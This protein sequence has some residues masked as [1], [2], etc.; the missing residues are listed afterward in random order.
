MARRSN[1]I[2]VN[3][4]TPCAVPPPED[5]RL[6]DV[7]HTV[8]MAIETVDVKLGKKIFKD[9]GLRLVLGDAQAIKPGSRET[10]DHVLNS[11]STRARQTMSLPQAPR[12]LIHTK[13]HV[14][15]TNA[16]ANPYRGRCWTYVFEVVP[17]NAAGKASVATHF[18]QFV[19]SMMMEAYLHADISVPATPLAS[20]WTSKAIHKKRRLEMHSSGMNPAGGKWTATESIRFQV[21]MERTVPAAAHYLLD[22]MIVAHDTLF[23]VAKFN[24]SS[25]TSMK[26]PARVTRAA[27]A[28][29]KKTIMKTMKKA[30]K[31]D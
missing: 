26:R 27:K 20:A 13:D 18:D 21:R 17:R 9:A 31:K 2:L 30:M 28:M 7:L 19:Q 16:L 12:H 25:E 4:A 29:K 10:Y 1:K 23:T 3:P 24:D 8:D 6:R 15:V 5:Y 11:L 14:F 22:A